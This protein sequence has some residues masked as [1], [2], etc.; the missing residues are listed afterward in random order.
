MP[1]N[2]GD[3][4]LLYTDGVT[5]PENATAIPLATPGLNKSFATISRAHLQNCRINCFPRYA[6]GNLLPCPSRTTSRSLSSTSFSMPRV[7]EAAPVL[8]RS[9][10]DCACSY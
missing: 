6:T 8:V 5:E 10:N 9:Q 3:R 1:I 7:L 2:P 4:F